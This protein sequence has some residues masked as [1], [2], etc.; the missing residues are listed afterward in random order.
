MLTSAL[1]LAQRAVEALTAV[2]VAVPEPIPPLWSFPDLAFWW[3]PREGDEVA[4]LG[5]AAE[6]R[7]RGADRFD[8][9]RR[10]AT[11]LLARVSVVDPPE[12]PPWTP[13]LHGGFAFAPGSA[14]APP[15]S[16][17]GDAGFQL[18]RALLRR[19]E[20]RTWLTVIGRAPAVGQVERIALRLVAA[21]REAEAA[22][23]PALRAVRQMSPAAW[24]AQVEE[25]RDAIA[26]RACEKIVLARRAEVELAA[27]LDARALLA[28][29]DARHPDCFRFA[30]RR[31]EALFAGASPERLVSVRGDEVETEAM[32]GS[33]APRGGARALLASR[34]DRG[35]HAVVTR[36]IARNL[37][38]LCRSLELAPAPEV[39]ALRHVM[40]L[41][42]PVR[43]RLQPRRHLLEVAAALHPTPAVGG[44]P[45]D[46]ALEWI[47][48]REAPRGWYAG[49]VG[50]FDREG[51]GELAVALRSGLV[52][53]DRAWVWAGAGIVAESDPDAEYAET[54]DKQRAFLDALGDRP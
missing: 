4:G 17:F 9:L 43:G 7:A 22:R 54:G 45:T 19:Q 50:W 44:E 29:L 3:A 6:L 23:P 16:E 13:R 47:A 30:V 39:R 33:I 27:P 41:C 11:E 12:A 49:A 31:G 53:A 2:T 51:D 42:T 46:R 24:R 5:V 8:E 25:V 1:P 18:P 38:P 35:E 26:A 52:L 36:A 20:G 10:R 48:A 34:K 21:A 28:R 15:W 37:A 14:D 32:A 40:H